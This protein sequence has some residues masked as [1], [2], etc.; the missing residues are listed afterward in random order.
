[1]L[2]DNMDERNTGQVP[3]SCHI[4]PAPPPFSDY[5]DKLEQLPYLGYLNY[6]VPVG[7]CLK[8]GAAWLS[9]IA[10]FYLYSVV[11]RWIKLIE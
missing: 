1:M 6:F 8:I 9:A 7:T 3:R 5:I 4:S 11:A 2:H 10:L